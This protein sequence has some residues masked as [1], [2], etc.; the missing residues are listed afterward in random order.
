MS[1]KNASNVAVRAIVSGMLV[2]STQG[3]RPN[4]SPQLLP[5]AAA[6][7]AAARATQTASL[8]LAGVPTRFAP[9]EFRIRPLAHDSAVRAATVYEL[10]PVA[11][12]SQRYQLVHV[13]GKLYRA[14]GFPA[15][16]L[17]QLAEELGPAVTQ[18]HQAALVQFLTRVL[19]V[20]S[21]AW[22]RVEDPALSEVE[23]DEGGCQGGFSIADSHRR[24]AVGDGWL[25]RTQMCEWF[26]GRSKRTRAAFI[27]DSTG[28]L[29]GWWR[30]ETL[31]PAH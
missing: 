12:H 29:A 9:A 10:L 31:V 26:P 1:M 2:A 3:C 8:N 19:A 7:V 6:A 20:D 17:R 18:H 22:L 30:A 11:N 5:P 23:G 24:I 27:F 16:E 13:N 21:V 4:P 14:G 28:G 15:P 25:W